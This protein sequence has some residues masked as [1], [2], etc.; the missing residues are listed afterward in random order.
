MNLGLEKFSP[1]ARDWF[2]RL[3]KHGSDYCAKVLRGS[4]R[5]VGEKVTQDKIYNFSRGTFLHKE[6]TLG[7]MM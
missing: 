1:G 2:P 3:L 4:Q 6:T 5:C 7:P